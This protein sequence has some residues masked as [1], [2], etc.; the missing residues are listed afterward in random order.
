MITDSIL[1]VVT[2]SATYDLT[3]L[4][5]VKT[6]LGISTND[7]D[8]R[9]IDLIH[10]ESADFADLCNRVFASE[11]VTETYRNV[12]GR[13][14]LAPLE[15]RRYPVTT[16]A[17]V[18]EDDVTLDPTDYEV[19]WK[20]GLLYRL[21]SDFRS[22]WCASKIIITYTGGYILLTTLPRKIE[23]A[24]LTMIMGRWF[25]GGSSARDPAV[26]TEDVYGVAR[27]D[28]WRPGTSS[29]SGFI[30]SSLPP[31]VQEAVDLYRD[32]RV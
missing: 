30:S 7:H 24:V 6:E 26:R 10:D 2:A 18:V 11:V 28:Y 8:D 17:S 22:V 14:N 31:D 16:V 23:T 9:L 20:T 12:R 21:S 29:S 5:R 15:L 3:T 13:N 4:D 27:I 32:M 19:D 25:S 1:E